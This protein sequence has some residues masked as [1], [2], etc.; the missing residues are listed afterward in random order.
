[1]LKILKNLK[2]SWVS[3]VAIVLL[4][5]LQ[6]A[7]D[8]ELPNYT[9]K[10]VNTGIQ[11]GGI[12]DAVP[13]EITIKDMESILLFTESDDRILSNYSV[14]N[15]KYIIKDIGKEEREELSNLL[16]EPIIKSQGIEQVSQMQETIKE[17]AA[18]A[19]V[20][21]FYKNVGVDT[22]KLQMNYIITAGLKMLGLA[23]VSMTA[24]ITIMMLSSR[25]GAKL[26]KTL[27]EK[28][29]NKVIRFSNKE[30]REFST[31]SLITRSTN[32][33]QQI[34]QLLEI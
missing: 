20:K 8:L 33:V 21:T 11:S 2:Q 3:V 18:V 24:G 1:M 5:C 4:L 30:L 34:Q 12:E 7:V 15:E 14:E 32:D 26:G 6:A 23:A 9:S 27:R 28:V 16:T 25:V 19:Y 17:Q 22:D 29:F 10:I 31:A 13:N